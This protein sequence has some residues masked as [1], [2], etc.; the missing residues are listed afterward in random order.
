MGLEANIALEQVDA[1]R[2]PY[3]DGQFAAIISN[4][5]VHHIPEPAAALAEACRVVRSGGLV[6][7]RDLLRP[8]TDAEV[9]ALVETYAGDANE[10]QRQL[11]DASLR[12]ALSLEEI[13]E[14][15]ATL[16]FDPDEARQTSD[17]HWTW[18]ARKP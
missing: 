8:R 11:F 3:A 15:V 4:S 1:K 14:I 9:R 5:I 13:R 10:R 17:R 18:I 6:F 2:L 7:V 16:G 12:A